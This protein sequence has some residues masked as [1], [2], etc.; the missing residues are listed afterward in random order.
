[1]QRICF[2]VQTMRKKEKQMNY[3]EEDKKLIELSA[4]YSYYDFTE[5]EIK[6][7]INKDIK[8]VSNEEWRML[9]Q[10]IYP[11]NMIGSGLFQ[12][13]LIFKISK[14]GKRID[15][16]IEA[17]NS[18]DELHDNN[19]LLFKIMKHIEKNSELKIDDSWYKTKEKILLSKE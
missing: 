6:K 10:M 14:S 12:G 19:C 5:K 2:I 16:P 13:I 7:V 9:I 15:P 3:K 1:M 11:K 8:D 17:Y 18:V 4:R